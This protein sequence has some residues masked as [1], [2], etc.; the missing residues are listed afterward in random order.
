[1][2][3]E[4]EHCDTKGGGE[5]WKGTLSSHST[6]VY[7]HCVEDHAGYIQGPHANPF[8]RSERWTQGLRFLRA[9]YDL[10]EAVRSSAGQLV[11]VPMRTAGSHSWPNQ[12]VAQ[13]SLMSSI[14][15]SAFALY[16]IV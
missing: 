5:K 14:P 6:V 12:R 13:A 10:S 1:V 16:S 8:K 7:C 3:Q 4:L 2:L 15:G 11:L 9:C